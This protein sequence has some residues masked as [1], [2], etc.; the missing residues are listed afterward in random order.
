MGK[1]QIKSLSPVYSLINLKKFIIDQNK[2]SNE[3]IKEF[4]EKKASGYYSDENKAIRAKQAKKD[5]FKKQLTKLNNDYTNKINEFTLEYNLKRMFLK[6]GIPE[7]NWI[8]YNSSNKLVFNWNKSSYN[9]EISKE[10][11]LKAVKKANKLLTDN[12]I[13]CYFDNIA[14]NNI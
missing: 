12:K 8:H 9:E 13:I 14:I 3:Q 6:C 7:F 4:K 10:T 5:A 2:I 11:A 1:N